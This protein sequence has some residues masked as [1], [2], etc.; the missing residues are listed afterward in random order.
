[1]D[2]REWESLCDG[3][4]Q[5]CRIKL[6]DASTGVVTATEIACRLL[7]VDTCRCRDYPNR[8]R[9]VPGCLQLTVAKLAGI[10]W[11]PD[12]CAYRRVAA[13]KDL[14]WWHPLVSGDPET[15]HLA[16]VSV[17]GSV[18][19]EAAIDDL[20]ALLADWYGVEL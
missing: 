11:L 19:S 15:V 2:D 7:D 8:R 10:D 12:T 5:C 16:G 14:E 18:V 4:G 9:R 1:M 20:R 3:C 17:R 6:E 13:G